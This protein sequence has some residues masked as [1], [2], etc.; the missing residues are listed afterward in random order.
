MSSPLKLLPLKGPAPQ[1]DPA[2]G[3]AGLPQRILVMPW[4]HNT[5]TQGPVIVNE[6]TAAK[7]LAYN[8]SQN[9][10]RIP[11]D[12]EHSSVPGSATYQGEPVKLAGYGKL[13][14]V[15]GEGIFLLM[16]SWTPDGTEYAAGGHYGDLS[17]VVKVNDQN[18]V[19]GL[20]SVA[21]CRHGATTG[22]IFLSATANTKTSTMDPKKP[23]NADELMK[24]LSEMLKLSADAT[25]TDILMSLSA[26]LQRSEPAAAAPGNEEVKQL[27]TA[28]SGLTTLV[29]QQGETLKL[30]TTNHEASERT[31]ILSQAAAEGKAVPAMAKDLTI[32]Q[33]KLLCAELPVTVPVGERK[34]DAT[35]LLTSN[36]GSRVAPEITALDARMGVTEEDRKK[37]L[38]HT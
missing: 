16:S 3:P 23:Q 22:L 19:I 10:D 37:Y 33:L 24:A 13:E 32:P 4:G 31:A 18:E 11:L 7:L 36:P 20:H 6:F 30:L 35:L 25:P 14:V 5:T 28:I 27:T 17:P 8:A 12:F 15:K 29:T 34:T 26:T 1:F 2:K 9:W 21:L 38:G